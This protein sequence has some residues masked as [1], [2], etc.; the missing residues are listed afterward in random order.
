M[1]M[2]GC[3][4]VWRFMAQLS[5]IKVISSLSVTI[6]I[7]FL[8]RLRPPL[9]LTS[10]EFTFFRQLLTVSGWERMAVEIISDAS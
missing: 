8:L 7:L 5:N 10:T 1:H 3:L 2:V 4:Y 9:W 6:L